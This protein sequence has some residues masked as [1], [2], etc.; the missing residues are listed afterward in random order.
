[1]KV[2]FACSSTDIQ[3]H[4]GTYNLIRKSLRTQGLVINADWIDRS[5]NNEKSELT[6]QENKVDIH[7]EAI[8]AINNIDILVADVSL[9]S[10]SVGYQI[11]L[12]LSKRI[13]VLC[14]YSEEFGGKEA[15]QVIQAINSPFLA[16]SGYNSK[17]IQNVIRKF[18]NNLP[19]NK[20]I[21]FNFIITPK[22]AEYLDAGSRQQKV[23]KSDF[24]RE[25]VEKA[26]ESN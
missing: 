14:L 11:G 21:K 18:I 12:A 7:D 9:P 1:M 3:Q 19:E 22:I 8:N 20:L 16:I 25:I 26:M 13:P 24:L 15:P 5:F 17:N 6:P 4:L 23:S 10:S 2:Y